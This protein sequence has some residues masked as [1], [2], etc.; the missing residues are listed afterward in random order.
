M[1]VNMTFISVN[2]FLTG[3]QSVANHQTVSVAHP[4]Q[5]VSTIELMKYFLFL[6]TTNMLGMQI[7]NIDI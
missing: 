5:L 2:V 4:L 6:R 3:N 7:K 1:H